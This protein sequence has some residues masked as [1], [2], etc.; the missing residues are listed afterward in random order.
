V[1]A[2]EVLSIRQFYDLL[3]EALQGVVGGTC[4]VEGEVSKLT[5]VRGHCYIDLVDPEDRSKNAG[6]LGL[7][8]W[9]SRWTG[10][11]RSLAAVGV[12]LAPGM[13]IRVRGSVDLY[14]PRGSV[15]FIVEEVDVTALLGRLAVE[16]AAIIE[17]LSA[18]GLLEANGRRPLPMA[19][20]RIGLVASQATEGCKDFLGQLRASPYAFEVL[21]CPATVQGATAPAE[22]RAALDTLEQVA[23]PVDLVVMVRGGG[24]KADL[25]CFDD[26]QLARQIAACSIPVWTGLGHT[27]D[28]AIADLVAARAH[29]T[30]T[31]CGAA[32][33]EH[34]S[35]AAARLEDAAGRVSEQV[36]RLL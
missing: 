21:L 1:A 30:P 32:L 33:V 13:L 17:A 35:W 9:Q 29:P 14:R 22:L 7:K 5:V 10:V 28:E 23:P 27:G 34:V 26:A 15:G 12:T 31:A 3:D 8:C 20:L 18:E 25:Q 19:P 24:A 4:W 11:E 36:A 2:S 16:R 6:V